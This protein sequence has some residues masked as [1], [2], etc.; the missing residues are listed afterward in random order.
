M[1]DLD[2]D[3]E[4]FLTEVTKLV[5]ACEP[6]TVESL[7]ISGLL[8]SLDTVKKWVERQKKGE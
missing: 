2:K 6:E 3:L 8:D 5:R 1:P 7:Q 4:R